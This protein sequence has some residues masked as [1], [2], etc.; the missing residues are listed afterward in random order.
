MT[1]LSEAQGQ[2]RFGPPRPQWAKIFKK[3]AVYFGF[4]TILV[5]NFHLTFI[6]LS[7]GCVG[8]DVVVF[9]AL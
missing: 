7:A 1:P 3:S 8:A 6:F 5:L 4:R 9:H 2:E